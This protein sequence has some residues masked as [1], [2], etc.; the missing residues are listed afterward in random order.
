MTAFGNRFGFFMS[1]WMVGNMTA[2]PQQ[3]KIVPNAKKYPLNH[4]MNVYLIAILFK[5]EALFL[6]LKVNWVI[7]RQ[8][9][10]RLSHGLSEYTNTRH[11]SADHGADRNRPKV[12]GRAQHRNGKHHAGYDY[13]PVAKVQEPVV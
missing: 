10:G 9:S 11:C 5:N 12:L 3:N 7:W 13:R 6:L 1:V 8:R 2:P 4:K